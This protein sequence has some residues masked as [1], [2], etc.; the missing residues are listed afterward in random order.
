VETQDT[1]PSSTNEENSEIFSQ[2]ELFD[3][4]LPPES[5]QQQANLYGITQELLTYIKNKNSIEKN[6]FLQEL[7]NNE[8]LKR[9]FL[10]Q[11]QEKFKTPPTPLSDQDRV[12]IQLY[13]KLFF[14][15]K[16]KHIA[17]SITIDSKDGPQ[18]K[19]LVELL[20]DG[21]NFSPEHFIQKISNILTLRTQNN[22]LATAIRNQLLQKARATINGSDVLRAEW[23]AHQEAYKEQPTILATQISTYLF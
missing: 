22:P 9:A 13:G 3:K 10:I 16:D 2:T 8:T 7:Q 21:E 23:I 17:N 19:L 5:Q 18:T 14:E 11:T 15:D 1:I 4:T 6:K 20:R 12:D